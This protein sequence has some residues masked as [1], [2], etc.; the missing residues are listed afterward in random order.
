MLRTILWLLLAAYLIS[1]GIW[2]AAAAPV[3][4]AFAGVAVL[5]GLVPG[6]AW[7]I[8]VAAVW[9]RHRRTAPMTMPLPVEG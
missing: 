3:S 9:W 5:I 1:V 4:L 7:L 2:P 6:P 8:A